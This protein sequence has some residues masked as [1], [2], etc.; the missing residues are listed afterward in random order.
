MRGLS[1]DQQPR[2][3]DFAGGK[4]ADLGSNVAVI[5]THPWGVLGGNM[6]NPVV[7]AAAHYFQTKVQV[8]TL[9]FDFCGSQIGFGTAQVRQLVQLAQD[10]IEQTAAQHILLVGYSYGALIAASITTRTI[11]SL[12]G[13]VAIA[14]AFGVAHWLFCFLSDS[15]LRQGK[16][17]DP[18]ALPRLFIMGDADNFTDRATLAA[19]LQKYYPSSS[20]KSV[21]LEGGVDHFFRSRKERELLNNI[22]GNWLLETFAQRCRNGD[23]T[24][25]GVV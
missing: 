8:T 22:I 5:I 14:P 2:E 18:A 24:K 11:P 25:F 4:L 20:S 16:D 17:E 1:L 10:V 7:V 13:L 12:I 21:V 6:H 15:L 23:L 9:R 19:T 3:R